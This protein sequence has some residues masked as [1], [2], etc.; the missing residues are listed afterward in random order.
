YGHSMRQRT[1]SHRCA[2]MAADLRAENLDEQVGAAIDHQRVVAEVRNRAHHAENLDDALDSTEVSQ[3]VL[4]FGQ[5][6]QPGYARMLVG[7]FDRQVCSNQPC[8]RRPVFGGGR[9]R[10]HEQKRARELVSEIVRQ[11]MPSWTMRLRQRQPER[12]D[13]LLRT[14]WFLRNIENADMLMA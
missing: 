9:A 10:P 7:P 3:R 1:H 14:H 12:R 6:V 13:L 2:R 8:Q 11:V 4:E 5:N